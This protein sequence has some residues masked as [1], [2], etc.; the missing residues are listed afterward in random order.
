MRELWGCPVRKDS[1]GNDIATE[2]LYLRR[3]DGSYCRFGVN[4]DFFA[5]QGDGRW[6]H[7]H[8]IPGGIAFTAN[9][10]GHMARY[11]E[12]YEKKPSDQ[13]HWTLNTAMRTIAGSKHT[14]WGTATALLPLENEQ[15]IA[16]KSCPFQLEGSVK[17][18]DW[19]RYRGYYDTDHS[20]RDE[21][22]QAGP[23]RPTLGNQQDW[24]QD[25]TYI[26]DPHNS[27]H[28]ALM[29]G[30]EVSGEEIERELGPIESWRRRPGNLRIR[31]DQFTKYAVGAIGRI[32]SGRLR[33]S[34][35]ICQKWKLSDE[36]LA[37]FENY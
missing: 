27:E 28:T 7:D 17:G 24:L 11:R 21:F 32:R 14:Q 31:A 10:T 34:L 37:A 4:L 13:N 35:A 30:E 33:E 8:R 6:W 20:V 23:E 5:V 2:T 3:P 22:F 12:W 1:E 19:T 9:A 25:F 36:E 29:V 18:K 15:P 16:A 26:Y